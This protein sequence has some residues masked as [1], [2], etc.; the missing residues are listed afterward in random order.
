MNI[1]TILFVLLVLAV[2]EVVPAWPHP[3]DRTWEYAPGEVLGAGLIIVLLLLMA[4]F[5]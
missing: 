1:A 5:F 3:H 2:L 4:R